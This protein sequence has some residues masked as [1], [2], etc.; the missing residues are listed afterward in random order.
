LEMNKYCPR[1][2]KHTVHKEKK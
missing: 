2:R 1:C